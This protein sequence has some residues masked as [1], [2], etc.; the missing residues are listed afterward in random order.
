MLISNPPILQIIPKNLHI[1]RSVLVQSTSFR[2]S[3]APWLFTKR[4]RAYWDSLTSWRHMF[5]GEK[6][7]SVP[8]SKT[9]CH[10]VHKKIPMTFQSQYGRTPEKQSSGGWMRKISSKDVQSTNSLTSKESV[11]MPPWRDWVAERT[12]AKFMSHGPSR[13][14]PFTSASW[15]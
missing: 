8:F 4:G 2:I 5:H 12:N 9:S 10:T 6:S 11:Q 14:G 15:K 1:K 3:S 13:N 7:T